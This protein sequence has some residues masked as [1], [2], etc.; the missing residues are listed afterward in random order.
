MTVVCLVI[1]QY[2]QRDDGSGDACGRTARTVVP[3][4]GRTARTVVPPCGRT[5]RT[6]VPPLLD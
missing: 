3:P 1:R 5:A 2:A 6:V 4:C